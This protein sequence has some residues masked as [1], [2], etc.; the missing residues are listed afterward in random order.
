M[1]KTSLSEKIKEFRAK[2]KKWQF[3]MKNLITVKK[4]D[5]IFQALNLPKVLNLNPRSIYNKLAEFVT[6]VQEEEVDL[7]C[8]SESWER[9]NLTLEEV[10][11]LEDHVVIS[12][13]H[14]RKGVGGRPAI[15]ANTKK[16]NVENLTQTS[17]PIP[18]GVEAV[19]ALLT[20]KNVTNASKIQKIAVCSLYSKP[21]SR[22][23]SLLHDH[24]SQVYNQLSSK[25]SKGLHWIICG[26]TNDLKLDPILHLNKNLKQVVLNPTRLDPPAMLDP[27]IT[28]L[29]NYYQEPKCLPPLDADPFTNGKPSDHLMVIMEPLTVINNKPARAKRT[30]TFR[31]FN[32]ERLQEMCEWIKAEDWRSI[33][34]EKSAHNKASALQQLLVQKY[35]E[36]FPEK[37][38]TFSSDDQPFFSEKLG[39]MKRRKC[40]EFR[41]NRKSAKWNGMDEI[42]Q[43][44][45]L[46]AKKGFYSNKIKNLRKANPKQW[47]REFKKL[48]SFDQHL[49]DEIV[50]ESIKDLPVTEQ[51]EL[52]ADKF[53]KVSQEYEEIKAEDI[54]IP[55][56]SD[57]DIP[58][59]TEKEVVEAMVEIDTSKSNVKNDIPAKLLKQ[60]APDLGK[61][62][63]DVINTAIRQ[64]LWPNSFKLE[65][66]TPV[67]KKFPP[68]NLEELRNISGLLNLNKIAEKL[69]A[70]LMISDMRKNIDPSQY[71]NQKGLSIQHY[72]VKF[73]DRIL[74]AIDK[75]SKSEICAVLATLVDWKEAFPRQ[76]PTL[77]V[78]SFI[79]NGVR[80]ALIPLLINY[81]QGRRM[82]V[83]WQGKVSTERELKGGGPQGST[84]GL[85][86]YL[87]QSNSN[88]DCISE[89]DRFKFV[90]DLTFIEIINLLNVG[91][92]SFNVRQQIPSHVPSH[93]QIIPTQNLNSQKYLKTINEWTEQQKM[94]LNIKKTKNIIFNFTKK[95]QFSTQLSVKSENIELV[96]EVKL[97]GT[98][99]TD[100]LKWDK[101]TK[102]IVIK[103]YK[104]MQLL[105]RAAKFTN[106]TSDL[107]SI[108]LTYVRSI[109]EQSAV[110][111][112][113]TLT[114]KNRRDLERVQKSA[115]RVILGR[116]YNTYK[117]G[118][119]KLNLDDLNER[120][121]KICLNFAKNCL[122]NE[123]V[124]DI[125][126]LK[127]SNHKMKKRKEKVY[128]VKNIKTERY[129]RSAI[130][131]MTN[132]LNIDSAKKLKMIQQTD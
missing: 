90:D 77:G 58:Q 132:L 33:S 56:F 24:I 93:N 108:Y 26:D 55:D 57:E 101:N 79:Q 37:K 128:K 76:C 124:K 112:H 28:T 89:S 109:L 103:A 121:R 59:F 131:Y 120:R 61:P 82:K 125:F 85:W 83:K 43:N 2:R 1:N 84:F 68:K 36:Y 114:T 119:K 7:I 6:F 75:N 99:I 35:E 69:I 98:Y 10:I 111:W 31:P 96:K 22:K 106:S 50:V 81:F 32:E 17:V 86:E 73:I 18:W 88:A 71:A 13:V 97:L 102:E 129:K 80:P 104:R 51:A 44:E 41:K 118:L 70:K 74:E 19:W 72:L 39:I 15:I 49:S 67:P 23:K 100:D 14:Q 95:Y 91:L 113:S 107:R 25:Y 8:M 40:R 52:I 117:E 48:A 42:Y 63:A 45:L 34:H 21:D 29:F 11:D 5:K 130:P 62:V 87:S 115:V 127:K 66:V 65:M 54:D 110:V 78:K 4:S 38:R 122:R 64:G 27:I 94:K 30:V 105:N 92:A 47:H 3:K 16:Y 116:K 46:K 9:E 53:A 60:L 126:P 12:N 20:P 123:K